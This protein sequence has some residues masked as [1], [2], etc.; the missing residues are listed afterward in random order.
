MNSCTGGSA[1]PAPI[2]A[3]GARLAEG[4]GTWEVG[5]PALPL[6]GV[7]GG[8]EGADWRPG[9]LG[10]GASGNRRAGPT[11]SQVEEGNQGCNVYQSNQLF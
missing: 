5:W 6:I 11:L 8:G 1:Q 3:V 10:G 7:R 9:W 4:K 2:G